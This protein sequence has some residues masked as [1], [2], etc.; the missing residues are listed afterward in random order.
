MAMADEL[1]GIL[2]V[3]S[4]PSGVGKTT[5]AQRLLQRGGYTRSIS[6]TTREKRPGEV[7]GRDYRFVSQQEFDRLVQAEELIEE[8]EVHE[9]HYGTPKEPLRKALA[10]HLTVLLVIDVKGAQQVVSKGLDALLIFLVAPDQQEL[11]R[12]LE[13]RGTESE[14]Q[15]T[16]RLERAVQETHRAQTLYDHFVVNADLEQCVNEVD[17]LVQAA[18]RRL[19]ERKQAG[20]T[21]YP[22]LG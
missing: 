14:R 3:L 10:D 21:L 5:V 16:V 6:V 9:S 4:G 19:L 13:R 18:R 7:D 8:A 15:R 17:Q 11:V 1:P 2:V 12:R 22:G 20:E